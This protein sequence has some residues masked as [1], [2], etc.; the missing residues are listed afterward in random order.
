MK[1]IEFNIKKTRTECILEVSL[2]ERVFAN[3]EKLSFSFLNAKEALKAE[4]VEFGALK[5]GADLVLQNYGSASRT[6][7]YI[8]KKAT[9]N[10]KVKA[11]VN[12][13]KKVK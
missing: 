7:T 2:P 10:R 6:G 13:K 1:N 3:D 12:A 5:D 11:P 8:F 4:E 9:T